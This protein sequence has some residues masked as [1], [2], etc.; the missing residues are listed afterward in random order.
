[1][2]VIPFSRAPHR[3]QP[4]RASGSTRHVSLHVGRAA[5]PVGFWDERFNPRTESGRYSA[6]PS[7]L[8][9][10]ASCARTA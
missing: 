7:W 1:M 2:R 8:D 4:C 9:W 5:A 10:T 3:H 6:R